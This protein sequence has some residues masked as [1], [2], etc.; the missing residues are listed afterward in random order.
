MKLQLILLLIQTNFHLLRGAIQCVDEAGAKVDWVIVYK[1]PKS[2]PS[3]AATDFV[4]SGRVNQIII[5]F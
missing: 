2:Q 5:F 4:K 1:L 3:A